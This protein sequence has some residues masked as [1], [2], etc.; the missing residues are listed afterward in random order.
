MQDASVL[1]TTKA[2]TRGSVEAQRKK[3]T[4]LAAMSEYA[5]LLG[6]D[7]EVAEELAESER[8]LRAVAAPSVGTSGLAKKATHSAMRRHRGSKDFDKV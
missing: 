7:S 4:E 2:A 1:A 6:Q 5:A 8:V 3:K